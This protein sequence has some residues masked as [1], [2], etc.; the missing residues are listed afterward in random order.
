MEDDDDDDDADAEDPD[1]DEVL[2]TPS[3]AAE[4]G[5]LHAVFAGLAPAGHALVE[6]DRA[7]TAVAAADCAEGLEA[8]V[9]E[10][11]EDEEA[12]GAFVAV[13]YVCPEAVGSGVAALANTTIAAFGSFALRRLG[14]FGIAALAACFLPATLPAKFEF[15]LIEFGRG[16]THTDRARA[17]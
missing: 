9:G 15:A 14:R 4:A 13:Q 12:S 5:P 6:D 2:A 3:A 16:R 17:G 11:D 8:S 1:D 7:P 10:A